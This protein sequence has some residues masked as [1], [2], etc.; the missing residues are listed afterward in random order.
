[1]FQATISYFAVPAT[2]LKATGKNLFIYSGSSVFC[3]I[4]TD[5]TNTILAFEK[6]HLQMDDE[7]LFSDFLLAKKWLS[8]NYEQIRIAVGSPQTTTVPA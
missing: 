1:M 6:Y 4:V 3:Y 2:E 7:K 5:T 8:G